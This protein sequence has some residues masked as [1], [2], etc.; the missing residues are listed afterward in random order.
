MVDR[1]A[2]ALPAD[3]TFEQETFRSAYR[4]VC[5]PGHPTESRAA[6]EKMPLSSGQVPLNQDAS[7]LKV[8]DIYAQAAVAHFRGRHPLLSKVLWASA[9]IAP[10]A[11]QKDMDRFFLDK[12]GD[13]YPLAAAIDLARREI[14]DGLAAQVPRVVLLARIALIALFLILQAIVFS[15]LIRAALADID[16]RPAPRPPGGP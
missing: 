9:T 4:A 1:W 7:R 13:T 3:Q 15:L 12:P 2:R 16:E 6:C 5:G 14:R 11:I 8:G 10:S